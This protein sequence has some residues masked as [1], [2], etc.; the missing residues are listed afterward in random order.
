MRKNKFE[1]KK[2][3]RQKLFNSK[4]IKKHL[5]LEC[6]KM[7]YIAV[8]KIAKILTFYKKCSNIIIDNK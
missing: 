7:Q 8:K 5:I 1:C 3:L 4:E 6:R 2:V